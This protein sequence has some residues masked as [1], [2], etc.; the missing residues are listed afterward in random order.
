MHS[1]ISTTDCGF[2][3]KKMKNCLHGAQHIGIMTKVRPQPINTIQSLNYI[4]SMC[5]NNGHT[6]IRLP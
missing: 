5:A 3:K 2:F 1:H 6:V 4:I